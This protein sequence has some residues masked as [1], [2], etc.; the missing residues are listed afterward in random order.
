MATKS[1]ED[2]TPTDVYRVWRDLFEKKNSKK[3]AGAIS[4]AYDIRLLKNAIEEYGLH[5]V[6]LATLSAF[7]KKGSHSVKHF[8]EHIENHVPDTDYPEVMYYVSFHGKKKQQELWKIVKLFREIWFPTH[9]DIEERDTAIE[10]LTA[11]MGGVKV[12]NGK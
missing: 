1:P 2:Y 4:P 3:Y 8:L 9:K 12:L 11:W 7:S 10:E 6:L 5:I